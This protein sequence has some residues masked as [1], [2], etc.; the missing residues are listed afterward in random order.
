EAQPG[1]GLADG[2]ERLAQQHRAHTL[3]DVQ[4]RAV[5]P[6]IDAETKWQLL[7]IAREALSNVAR[8]AAASQVTVT[9]TETDGLVTLEIADNGRGFDVNARRTAGQGLRNIAD[10]AAAIGG[11]LEITSTLGYGARYRVTAPTQKG[12][13]A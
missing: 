7:Q 8:H 6:S 11:R 4:V 1:A 3:A 9:L 12:T 10:R 5:E 13:T 2:L